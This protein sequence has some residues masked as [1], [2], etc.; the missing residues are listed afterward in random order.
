MR[1]NVDQVIK[2]LEEDFKSKSETF[3]EDLAV[4][5][6]KQTAEGKTNNSVIETTTQ[7]IPAAVNQIQKQK[8][9][10][11]EFDE[12]DPNLSTDV[13]MISNRENKIA[14]DSK[15]IPDKDKEP[16]DVSKNTKNSPSTLNNLTTAPV[17]QES[18]AKPPI[19]GD[20]IQQV[21]ETNIL[22]DEGQTTTFVGKEGSFIDTSKITNIPEDEST[23][24]N[25]V[26]QEVDLNKPAT[27]KAQEPTK[28][29]EDTN[30]TENLENLD[31]TS[32]SMTTGNDLENNTGQNLT[33]DKQIQTDPLA[34]PNGIPSEE[35][36]QKNQAV[37]NQ[38][39]DG[40]E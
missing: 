9:I 34:N 6:T 35:E 37:T 3:E 22:G 27:T 30:A 16:T 25:P 4:W 7:M 18:T 32:T 2:Q 1:E 23:S 39:L 19:E 33:P 28:S 8:S 13:S 31:S 36:L 12:A 21:E 17:G 38:S 11:D 40:I 29:L 10:G 14:F 26:N 20:Q 15:I 5:K 24:G